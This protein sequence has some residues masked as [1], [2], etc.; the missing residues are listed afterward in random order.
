MVE[1]EK[2][3]VD[4]TEEIGKLNL[5][6]LRQGPGDMSDSHVR[7][8]TSDPKLESLYREMAVYKTELKNMVELNTSLKE[9]LKEKNAAESAGLSQIK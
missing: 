1:Y 7:S 6:L 4:K 2:E 9:A 3:I 5:A 8:T